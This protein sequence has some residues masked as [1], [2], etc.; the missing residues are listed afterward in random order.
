MKAV[1]IFFN[2]L[3]VSFA[4]IANPVPSKINEV[5]VYLQGALVSRTAEVQI[6]QGIGEIVLS[7]LPIDIDPNSIQLEGKGDFTVLS[8]AYR[9]SH[10]EL[11]QLSH[12]L[13]ILK[14]S[15]EYYKLQIDNKQAM[16]KVYEEE[17]SF[18]LA[19]KSIGG[20]NETVQVADLRSIADFFRSRLA[21]VK[22]RQIEGRGELT[23]L[24]DR[25]NRINNQINELHSGINR[26]VGQIVVATSAHRAG[27][28]I[29]NFSFYV[30]NAGWQPLYDIRANDPASRIDLLMKANV[31]QSTG[32]DW[33]NIQLT[34][35]TGSP[36]LGQQKPE[37]SP[38]FLEL[39]T[40]PP[41]VEIMDRALLKSLRQEEETM[42]D[43]EFHLDLGMMESAAN[44][45]ETTQTRTTT[46]YRISLPY[47]VG[48]GG[49]MQTVEV[50]NSQLD[51]TY[52]YY[53]IPKLDKDVFLVA[54]STGWEE[55]IKLPGEANLFFDGVYVGKTFI[56]PAVTDDTLQL[57]LGRDRS[58]V[59][60]RKRM[61]DF[62]KKSI[63]GRRTTESRAWEINIRN[64][65][66]YPVTIHL[67]DQ[68]PIST[69]T[70]LQVEIE[71][72]SGATLDRNTGML[73]WKVSLAP[74]E[75]QN[76]V[77]RYSVRY[78]SDRIIHLE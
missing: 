17:E 16:I 60:E 48:G 53:A 12:N 20:K 34:L 72:I 61:G 45:V 27:R 33:N 14:D 15:L 59:V 55:Y 36:A 1:V 2:I 8:V 26:P 69:H 54:N 46:E 68:V 76:K 65:K 4:T 66:N 42:V 29:L 44:Y 21:D 57:S 50:L 31:F 23:K 35:S 63:L 7:G 28:A 9:L 22:L 58:I 39:L 19:N 73:L 67:K 71:E 37:L 64:T 3:Y 56:D 5:K 10:L 47:N 13:R 78:P 74:N 52:Q 51:A 77:F 43:M 24:Q 75:T 41:P 18:L 11:P 40:P 62:T 6:P 70:D 38:W 25:Y 30:P 49:Q 32:E